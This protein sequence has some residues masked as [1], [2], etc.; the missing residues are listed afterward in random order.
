MS[1]VNGI[2]N[3][4]QTI[5]SIASSAA[6]PAVQASEANKSTLSSPKVHPADQASLSATAGVVAQALEGSDVRAER[7]ASLQN[8]IS[9]G[10]YSV[11]SSDVADKIIR[12]LSE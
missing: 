2:G 3:S 8:A 10:S 4:Q 1:Y 12:S 5:T 11:P 9:A 7:V 6:T